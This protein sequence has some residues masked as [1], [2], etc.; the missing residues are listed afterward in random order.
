MFPSGGS[1]EVLFH[2]TTSP[3][4]KH[5]A[6][7]FTDLNTY[8]SQYLSKIGRKRFVFETQDVGL[9]WRSRSFT[10]RTGNRLALTR[11]KY[12]QRHDNLTCDKTS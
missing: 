6:S 12:I 1:R 8:L 3:P 4:F 5:P 10:K 11:I 9:V 2:N 7:V